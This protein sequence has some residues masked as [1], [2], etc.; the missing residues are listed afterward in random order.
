MYIWIRPGPW[1]SQSLEE[2]TELHHPKLTCSSLYVHLSSSPVYTW[3]AWSQHVHNKIHY[4]S[5]W[6][7]TYSWFPFFGEGTVTQWPMLKPGSPLQL[8]FSFVPHSQQIIQS[9]QI[10]PL[11][12][13][14][15]I[16][17]SP[18]KWPLIYSFSPGLCQTLP[19]GSSC[20]QIPILKCCLMLALEWLVL[21]A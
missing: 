7:Y 16:T 1:K 8:P 18:F 10:C 20:P 2:V 12:S 9:G 3:G 4:P 14:D 21:Y 19:N 17:P 11:L 13:L 5:L 15:F 6:N